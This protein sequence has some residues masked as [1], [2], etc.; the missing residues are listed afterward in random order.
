MNEKKDA[1][2]N[3]KRL[4]GSMPNTGSAVSSTDFTG[5]VPALTEE[6][7]ES[8]N[9]FYEELYGIPDPIMK[10]SEEDSSQYNIPQ[11]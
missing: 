10:V 6:G 4:N 8:M 1:R 5:L 3:D 11:A 2:K 9:E 7:L